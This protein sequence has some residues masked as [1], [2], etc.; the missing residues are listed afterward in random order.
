MLFLI[1]S[2]SL[3]LSLSLSLALSLS[4][5]IFLNPAIPIFSNRGRHQRSRSSSRNRAAGRRNADDKDDHEGAPDDAENRENDK[6][7]PPNRDE[8]PPSKTQRSSGGGPMG[9]PWV[10]RQHAKGVTGSTLSPIA[11]SPME[12]HGH[13]P[14]IAAAAA[15]PVAR[16]HL[17]SSLAGNNSSTPKISGVAA[18]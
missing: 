4:L 15:S 13:T 10:H 9:G 5:N 18:R 11:M 8:S 16:K 7:S 6:D 3:F 17:A 2:F 12:Q 1:L 14:V